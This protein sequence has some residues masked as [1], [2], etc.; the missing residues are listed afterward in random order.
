MASCFFTVNWLVMIVLTVSLTVCTAQLEIHS[1]KRLFPLGFEPRTSRVWGERDNH[2]TTETSLTQDQFKMI[3][4]NRSVKCVLKSKW[5]KTPLK[6]T[7]RKRFEATWY[8]YPAMYIECANTLAWLET[9]T[10]TWF[11]VVRKYLLHDVRFTH[12]LDQHFPLYLR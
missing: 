6:E 11:F 10:P 7:K 5:K 1:N 12:T 2:Y 9:M 3:L 4:I 8:I